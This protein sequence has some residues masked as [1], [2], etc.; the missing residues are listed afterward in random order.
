MS[1]LFAFP[2]VSVAIQPT[3]GFPQS[4]TETYRP[5]NISGFAGLEKPKKI[6]H[7]L[8][9]APRDGGG[10]LFVGPSGTGK[11]SMA[12]ALAAEIPAELH[13]IPSQE[14]NLDTIERVWRR[15]NY[16][17]MSGFRKHL[18]LIDEADRM[19]SAAQIAL[20]S[21]LDSTNPAPDTLVVLTC[22]STDSLEPRF[23]SR[24]RTV[25]FSSYGI[26]KDAAALMERVWSAETGQHDNYPNYPNF[27]RIVKESN[28]NIRAALMNLEL[29]IMAA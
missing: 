27:A 18:I 6:M 8:A 28:N 13:H 23:L 16:V 19:T 10:W 15:C 22:N 11:T 21:R 1:T 29:E 20:L 17:P 4:L 25:E 12:M 7:N 26:A 3:L 2:D 14:C 24:C 5:R 9:R